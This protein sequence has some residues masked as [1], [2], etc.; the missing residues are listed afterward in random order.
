MDNF[1]VLVGKAPWE[2][3]SFT[4]G[5]EPL[6]LGI[7]VERSQWSYKWAGGGIFSTIDGFLNAVGSEKDYFVKSYF[8][9]S[10]LL[11][12]WT[13]DVKR[14]DEVVMSMESVPTKGRRRVYDSINASIEKLAESNRRRKVLVYVGRPI[15]SSSKMSF[16]QL[17]EAARRSDVTV[18][19][20]SLFD[21]QDVDAKQGLDG[22]QKLEALTSITGGRSHFPRSLSEVILGLRSFAEE[23]DNQYLITINQPEAGGRWLD[24]S[25]RT[26]GAERESTL[27]GAQ[28]RSRKGFYSAGTRK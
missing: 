17:I 1:Q 25:V 4:D 26:L 5:F 24:L 7:L 28:I 3:L 15:D 12:D 10:D 19:S 8:D 9:S 22:Q 2:I 6:S 27:R 20:I 14:Y 11:I 21:R 16:R 13:T 23:L 18:F